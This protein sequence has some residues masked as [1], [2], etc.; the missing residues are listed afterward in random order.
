[1]PPWLARRPIVVASVVATAISAPSA[2][3]QA[4]VNVEKYALAGLAA[5]SMI[6]QINEAVPMTTE[7]DRRAGAANRIVPAPDPQAVDP[8]DQKKQS[9]PD[10]VE[11]LFDRQRPVV[12][13]GRAETKPAAK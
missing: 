1:M 11:L 2:S 13:E 10:E 12:A 5:V 6:D 8:D 7:R 9:R 4:R 3:S